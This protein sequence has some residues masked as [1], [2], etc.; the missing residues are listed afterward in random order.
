MISRVLG[1]MGTSRHR[2][3]P[4]IAKGANLNRPAEAL[5]TVPDPG[6]LHRVLVG[7]IIPL[8][9]GEIISL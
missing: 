4:K 6:R 7:R 8:H 9:P 3:L 1:R 5:V 2:S